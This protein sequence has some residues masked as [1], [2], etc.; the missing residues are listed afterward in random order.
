MSRPR[1]TQ[2]RTHERSRGLTIERFK[3]AAATRSAA[4][5]LPAVSLIT[6]LFTAASVPV[7]SIGAL[8]VHVVVPV[9]SVSQVLIR[10]MRACSSSCSV[11]R[12]LAKQFAML[13]RPVGHVLPLVS[14]TQRT[15]NK[16]ARRQ[17][18]ARRQSSRARIRS[19]SAP[20]VWPPLMTTG[21]DHSRQGRVFSASAH[22]RARVAP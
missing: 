6:A 7:D 22:W 20:P 3:H 19:K 9:F 16:D 14:T 18:S 8:S 1:R 15:A 11:P 4:R 17:R 5:W 2:G 12:P 13:L 21:F 10:V